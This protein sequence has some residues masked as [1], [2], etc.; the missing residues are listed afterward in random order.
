M[1]EFRFFHAGV[2]RT[3]RVAAAFILRLLHGGVVV[4]G[5]M[6]IGLAVGLLMMKPTPAKI[7]DGVE[8]YLGVS[9]VASEADGPWPA[10]VEAE[11]PDPE[12]QALVEHLARRYRVAAAALH[13]MV[14]EAYT[15]AKRYGLDPMLLIAVIAVESRFNP[16]AE[17]VWGARGLM[18]VIPRYHRDRLGATRD[19]ESF[20]HPETNI[21]IG[22]QILHE[23]LKSEGSVEAALQKYAGAVDDPEEGYA[24]RVL[25]EKS[26]LAKIVTRRREAGSQA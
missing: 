26:R 12:R 18:Q 25:A 10:V 16:I 8:R 20:L 2:M 17:S 9:A 4:I 3:G 14:A 21:R 1:N 11:T 5:L 19:D 7:A 22:A 13:P 6:V 23:Y 24:A 15:S